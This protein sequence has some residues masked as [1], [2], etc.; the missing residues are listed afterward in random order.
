MNHMELIYIR[1]DKNGTKYFHDWKCPRCGGAGFADK[2]IATGR[3]C[4]ECGGTGKR[5]TPKTVKEYTDEYAAKLDARR[6]AADE[7]RAAAAAKYAEEH[8]DEIAEITRKLIERRYAEFGCGPDGIGYVHEGK[9]W[10]VKDQI[11]KAGGRWIYGVWVCP[12]E[13]KA[14]GVRVHTID[15]KG[16]ISGGSEMWVDDF[17][18]YEAIHP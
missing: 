8:A 15:L 18:L 14:D 4:Y 3:V 10:G 7:K 9:T 11:K 17:D 6:R 5:A 16:H 12:V 1:T 13:F 2:W